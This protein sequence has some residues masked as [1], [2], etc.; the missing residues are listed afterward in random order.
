MNEELDSTIS[1]Q[2]CIYKYIHEHY[3]NLYAD[4]GMIF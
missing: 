2:I 4:T 1:T 3:T